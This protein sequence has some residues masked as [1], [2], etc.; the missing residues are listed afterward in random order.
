[1]TAAPGPVYEAIRRRRVTRQ[2]TTEP[3][4]PRELELISERPA[5]PRTRATAACS[6]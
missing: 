6:R 4:D 3:V 1:M 5:T 2:M